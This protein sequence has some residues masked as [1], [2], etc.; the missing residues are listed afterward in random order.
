MD[1]NA[2]I[3]TPAD[4]HTHSLSFLFLK[5]RW[6]CVSLGFLSRDQRE[7]FFSFSISAIVRVMRWL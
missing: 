6:V 4:P 3:S 5:R 2:Y 7:L 1:G